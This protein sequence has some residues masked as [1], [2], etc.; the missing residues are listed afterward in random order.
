VKEFHLTLQGRNCHSF[1]LGSLYTSD[2][3]FLFL[4][5]ILPDRKRLFKMTCKIPVAVVHVRNSFTSS[6][7]WPLT[8]GCRE[9]GLPYEA[10]TQ[11]THSHLLQGQR[12]HYRSQDNATA[13][14][15]EP[16][17]VDSRPQTQCMCVLKQI[18][19]QMNRNG[20]LDSC[21]LAHFPY[22]KK[23]GNEAYEIVLLSVCISPLALIRKTTL[24]S[25]YPTNLYNKAYEATLLS[26]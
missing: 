3:N 9:Q 13:S 18:A 23:K 5:E 8:V 25:V 11:L 6:Q 21:F 2:S 10:A 19:A 20:T 1:L 17:A 7:K 15:S 26:V 16:Y 24:L 14:H 22:F 4:D 12:C